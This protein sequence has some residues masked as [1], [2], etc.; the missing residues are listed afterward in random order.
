MRGVMVFSAA[1]IMCSDCK[2]EGTRM[3]GWLSGC[4]AVGTGC[5]LGLADCGIKGW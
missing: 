5:A 4:G 2:V 3:I 1:G